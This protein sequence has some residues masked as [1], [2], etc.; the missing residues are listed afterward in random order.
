MDL[1]K[2]RSKSSGKGGKKFEQRDW[3]DVTDLP[4][5]PSQWKVDDFRAAKKGSKLIGFLDITLGSKKRTMGLRKG[6]NLDNIMDQLG[7]NTDKWKGKK[8]ELERGG[9]DDQ[10]V[11]VS[12]G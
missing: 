8:L 10:Y 12:R 2:Q 7:T 9:S 5:K 4:R 6:F 1:G 11:N 3:V